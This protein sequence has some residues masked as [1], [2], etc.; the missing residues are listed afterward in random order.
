MLDD[1]TICLFGEGLHF[2]AEPYIGVLY[3]T[4]RVVKVNY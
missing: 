4:W 1:L 2:C 3:D